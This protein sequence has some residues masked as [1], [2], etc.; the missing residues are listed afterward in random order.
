MN[1]LTALVVFSLPKPRSIAA[2]R[3]WIVA[4]VGA[5]ASD[6]TVELASYGNR[7]RRVNV[8]A[9]SFRDARVESATRRDS[10]RPFRRLAGSSPT[11]SH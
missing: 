2:R 10:E 1:S 8:P 9:S 3:I 5:D 6:L 7:L 4:M 11:R